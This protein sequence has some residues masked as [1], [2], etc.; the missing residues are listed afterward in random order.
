MFSGWMACSWPGLVAVRSS[1]RLARSLIFRPQRPYS[2]LLPASHAPFASAKPLRNA[3]R[4][5]M[6]RFK[7]ITD[8]ITDRTGL[9]RLVARWPAK[10]YDPEK[11][12][13]NS[14]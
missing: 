9:D 3:T 1:E 7:S 6:G 11:V 14:R 10:A 8:S 13:L 5:A 12:E 4:V 2:R